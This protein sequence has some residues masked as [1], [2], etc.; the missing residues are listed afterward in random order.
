MDTTANPSTS[1]DQLDAMLASGALSQ[2]DYE[3][4]R[5]AIAAETSKRAA[6][7]KGARPALRK[8][9]SKRQLGGVCAG[10][11]EWMG[12]APG[13]IRAGFVL[14][15]ILTSGSAVLVYI[16]LYLVLPWNETERDQIARFSFRFAGGVFGLWLALQGLI[17]FWAGKLAHIFSHS[18]MRLPYSSRVA[19]ELGQQNWVGIALQVCVLTV[20]VILYSMIP[21][22]SPLRRF[23]A[24]VVCGGL[25][26]I[27]LVLVFGAFS[28]IFTLGAKVR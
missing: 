22:T 4:L 26:L 12:I 17:Y 21:V 23:F 19:I 10:L 14:A 13:P 24:G 20:I 28:A 1:L 16:V 9:W 25:V 5:I 3:T 27:M 2:G 15:A 7:E 18:G 6:P 8:S 11:G